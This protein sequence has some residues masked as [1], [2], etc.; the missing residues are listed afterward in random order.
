MLIPAAQ[1][2]AEPSMTVNVAGNGKGEAVSKK[3]I[4]G[5]SG[6][7]TPTIAC[8]Y[9]GVSKSGTC[10]NTP[11]EPTEGSGFFIELLVANPAP[12]SEF[13]GWTV[14]EGP[15][16]GEFGEF[17]TISCPA[18][19]LVS[20]YVLGA[21][22]SEECYFETIEPGENEEWEATAT[23]CKEG[24]AIEEE[25]FNPV[26][27]AKEKRLVGCEEGGGGPTNLRDLTITKSPD[28]NL[29]EGIGSVSS[30]PKGIKCG[31][32]CDS[33]T[34]AMY[35]ET[36]VELT[37]KPSTGSTFVEWTGACSGNSLTCTVPMAEDEEVEAV[38]GGTSKPFSP[39]EALTLNKEGS[40]KGGVKAS[41]LA[42]EADCTSTVSLYQ[43]PITEPKAKAGKIVVLKQA[44][45][46]GSE[47]SGWS[48]CDSEPEGNCQVAME[49]A[50][51]VTAEYTALPNKVLTIDKAYSTGN[52]SVASK[53]KGIKCGTTCT[54][55]VASMPQGAEVELSA[56]PSTGTFVEWVGG[57]C[58]ESTNPVCVVTMNS[59][60]TTEAV[61]SAVGKAIAEA[62]TL[63]LAKEGS[64]YGTVKASGL[65]CEVL[66]TSTSVL[67]Q[68]PIG[69]EKPKAGKLV[70]LKAAPAPG[71][72]AVE[73]SG[74]TPI[75]PTECEVTIA[76]STEVTATFNELE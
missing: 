22:P 29:G 1:A 52:G 34:A 46:F 18:S 69:G 13:G 17:G 9:N 73:W 6:E 38:F 65:A 37:A 74:C 27:E 45:A 66:C 25:V 15:F 20:N 23:F 70:V 75:S 56:K 2:F 5:V 61:F 21:K 51:E 24:T 3:N 39:P 31:T 26:A 48:G 43:G 58:D 55:A 28:P 57:D 12:G 30:K 60:E 68:G 49:T 33:A 64:G 7:G 63:T 8:S 72:G 41:G 11:D 32:T 67:Y 4:G 59:D 44:P 42:C 53:P 71:S 10:K 35:K 40:G 47:F 14:Q 19:S 36:P 16:F 54:Q 76:G 50:Q 62:K